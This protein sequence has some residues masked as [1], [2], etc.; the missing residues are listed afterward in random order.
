MACVPLAGTQVPPRVGIFPPAGGSIHR[1]DTSIA[2]KT[3]SLSGLLAS[4]TT[5]K[6]KNPPLD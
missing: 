5:G 4:R 2:A 3:I 6:R 1:W